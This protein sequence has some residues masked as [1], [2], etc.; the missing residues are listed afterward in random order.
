VAGWAPVDREEIVRFTAHIPGLT[1]YPGTGTHWW[2]HIT[3][4]EFREIARETDRL[5]YDYVSVSEHLI[6]DRESAPELGPRWSNS[7]AAAGVLLGVMERATV[8]PLLVVP[9]HHPVELAKSLAT[10]DF[11]S[12]GRVIPQCM[13]GYNQREFAIMNV[14]YA[15]RGAIMDE[16]MDAMI[17]LWGSD[18]P[19]FRGAHVQF[20]DIVFEPRPRKQPM[21]LWFGGRTKTAMRRIAR[22]GDGWAAQST[23]PRT[24]L[25]EMVNLI[26]EQPEFQAR[27]RPLELTFELFEGNRD[28][29]T[30]TLI[31]Q[32]KISLEKEVIL[33]Q[34]Q[35]IAD[36]GATV[37][38][39]DDLLGSG[40]YQNDRPD[41][42]P[43]TRS[44]SEHLERVH[45]FAEE[46]MPE[47]R[48]ITGSP[49]SVG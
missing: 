38:S 14:D 26:R 37:C 29:I 24:R 4:P 28:P 2:E 49:G 31:E 34:M 21:T 32:A 7:M 39:V 9:Y 3:P 20:D 30:H 46:I 15:K 12:G 18:A 16:W 44:A 17:E 5:G 48:R 27:P 41:A 11:L 36:L 10:L 6:M 35:I 45:W 1:L 8:V 43:P 33:E 40:K 23:V 19:V 42:P 25:R 47:G 22:L 13:V